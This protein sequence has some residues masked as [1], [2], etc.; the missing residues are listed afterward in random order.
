[1]SQPLVGMDLTDLR[2]ALG[3]DQPGYRAKQIYEAIYRGQASGLVQISTLPVRL[4][5]DLAGRHEWGLPRL[6]HLYQSSDGTRRYLLELADGRTVE[7][8]LMPE[9]ERDTI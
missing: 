3:P 8:V 5:Q 6:A 4:R 2:E 7:T 1:M 9:G